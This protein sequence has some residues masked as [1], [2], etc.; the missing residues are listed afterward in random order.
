M[1]RPEPLITFMYL[2]QAAVSRALCLFSRLELAALQV[3]LEGQLPGEPLDLFP[4]LEHLV[5]E[6]RSDGVPP[7]RGLHGIMTQANPGSCLP[8]CMAGSWPPA[9]TAHS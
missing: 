4:E 2:L 6:L 3:D 1:H 7:R 9:W 5:V 8:S